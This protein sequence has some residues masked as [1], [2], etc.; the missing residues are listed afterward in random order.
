MARIARLSYGPEGWSVSGFQQV[1]YNNQWEENGLYEDITFQEAK[2]AATFLNN[3]APREVEQLLE[4]GADFSL[5]VT[6]S[7]HPEASGEQFVTFT[8][9]DSSK[10]S[11][12]V[13][14]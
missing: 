2:N 11:W 5:G 3:L 12:M 13:T 7:L 6:T 10:F 9:A 14:I 8:C 4:K 1:S